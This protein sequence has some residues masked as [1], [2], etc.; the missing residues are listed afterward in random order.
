VYLAKD[1]LN[2][3]RECFEKALAI[4]PSYELARQALEQARRRLT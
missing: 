1:M 2:K 3:A 4:E